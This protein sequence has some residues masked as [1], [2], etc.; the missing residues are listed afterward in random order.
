MM[1]TNEGPPPRSPQDRRK[2]PS[3]GPS[4]ERQGTEDAANRCRRH[5]GGHGVTSEKNFP[6]ISASA[7]R[8]HE[9]AE[10]WLVGQSWHDLLTGWPA[11]SCSLATGPSHV[12]AG[13]RL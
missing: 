8:G 7:G 9:Q 13:G 10:V 6:T 3:A 4:S 1:S 2:D 5:A 11:A 12:P